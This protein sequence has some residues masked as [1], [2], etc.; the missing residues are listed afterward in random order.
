MELSSVGGRTW[1]CGI[2]KS[3]Y[4][5]NTFPNRRGMVD[6]IVDTVQCLDNPNHQETEHNCCYSNIM[7]T[8]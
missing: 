3:G 8:I 4:T 5:L 2:C 7:L 6:H 1:I